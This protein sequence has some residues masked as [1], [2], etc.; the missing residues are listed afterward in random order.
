MVIKTIYH[1]AGSNLGVWEL[2]RLGGGE[3]G[4]QMANLGKDLPGRPV[5]EGNYKD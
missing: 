5:A 4:W 2:L 1:F 3:G